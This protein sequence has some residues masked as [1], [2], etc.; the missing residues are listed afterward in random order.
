MM[1]RRLVYRS[2]LLLVPLVLYL[3]LM[4][5]LLETACR[6][7]NEALKHKHVLFLP[8]E[9][10]SR[11]I[12]QL[13]FNNNSD[14]VDDLIHE[15]RKLENEKE[16]MENMLRFYMSTPIPPKS[17][18][19]ITKESDI[20]IDGSNEGLSF[21]RHRFNCSNIHIINLQSKIGH[22]VS[23]Q[24]FKG[25]FRGM[26]IAVKMVTRHQKEVKTCIDAINS[27]DAKRTEERAKC[28]VHP[29]MKIMKEILLLEQL[30]HPG[31]VKLLGYCVR[32]EESDTSDLSE[33]G[34]VSVFELGQKLMLGNLQL[35]TWQERIRHSINLADF[36]HYLEHSPLGSL[37][38]RDFKEDHFLMVGK[39]IK[40]IDLDDV[41]DIEPSCDDYLAYHHHIEVKKSK[42]SCDFGLPCNQGLCIGFNAKHNLKLMNIIF[43]KRLLYP[44]MFP[45]SICDEIGALNADIDSNII[46]ASDIKRRLNHLLKKGLDVSGHTS[47]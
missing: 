20:H 44:N 6:D 41:D 42:T 9:G 5:R 40:M 47:N 13:K 28:F 33:R 21:P 8:S 30:N 27:S 12:M 14:N 36:L 19:D 11:K 3:V 32:S 43:F 23:K 25:S 24:T 16:K 37:V 2:Y 46:T 31:F 35:T 38:V 39:R 45:K 15:V 22:G 18:F 34:I 17:G 10:N 4:Y 1:H 29:T 26:P 7:S